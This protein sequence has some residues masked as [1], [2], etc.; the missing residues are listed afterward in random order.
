MNCFV[1]GQP[2]TN[3]HYYY[4]DDKRIHKC[5]KCRPKFT[6]SLSRHARPSKLKLGTTI[7]LI[8]GG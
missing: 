5:A 7:R 2:L 8:K 4:D 3:H 6:R 1:C